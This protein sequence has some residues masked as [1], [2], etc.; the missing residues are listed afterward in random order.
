MYRLCYRCFIVV[1]YLFY[2]TH[3]HRLQATAR[4]PHIAISRLGTCPWACLRAQNAKSQRPAL[5]HALALALR[6]LFRHSSPICSCNSISLPFSLHIRLPKSICPALEHA[7][8]VVRVQK[9]YQSKHTTFIYYVHVFR[10]SAFDSLFARRP[11]LDFEILAPV[12][13]SF[14]VQSSG[15]QG[16][17]FAHFDHLFPHHDLP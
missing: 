13:S 6:T 11:T 10:C 15:F 14:N 2:N 17:P 1:L 3:L 5:D 7:S 12:A 16:S 4:T 8:P 9:T